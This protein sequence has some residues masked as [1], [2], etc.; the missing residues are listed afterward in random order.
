MV[1]SGGGLDIVILMLRIFVVTYPTIYVRLY[2]C[3]VV[4]TQDFLNNSLNSST[5]CRFILSSFS[6]I[7]NGQDAFCQW[8]TVMFSQVSPNGQVAKWPLKITFIMSSSLWDSSPA[9]PRNSSSPI[10]NSNKHS[11]SLTKDYILP[12]KLTWIP[13]MMFF[14]QRW[15]LFPSF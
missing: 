4:I 3:Q 2:T 12:R 13:K 8:P 1:T 11:R 5:V 9:L 6:S 14:F 10:V 15:L 7:P